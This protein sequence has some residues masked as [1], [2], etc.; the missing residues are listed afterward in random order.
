MPRY[1]DRVSGSESGKDVPLPP[2]AGLF[3]CF[4]QQ[5]WHALVPAGA[6]RDGGWD[7]AHLPASLPNL[8]ARLCIGRQRRPDVLLII[9]CC[10]PPASSTLCR[11]LKS[12]YCLLG[13]SEWT[14]H[15]SKWS[16]D[17]ALPL[18]LN[19]WGSYFIHHNK[20]WSRLIF[21]VPNICQIYFFLFNNCTRQSKGT[22]MQPQRK[23]S[24]T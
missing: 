16:L 11:F 6:V 4:C 2:L 19:E 21:G 5:A 18:A 24:S 12:R 15:P 14:S 17:M 10:I 23:T 9:S 20:N 3:K 13:A 22:S 1:L 8:P 7:A